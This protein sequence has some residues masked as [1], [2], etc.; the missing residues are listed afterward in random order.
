MDSID[1]KRHFSF[2]F[3]YYW[4][5][6]LGA[7]GYCSDVFAVTPFTNTFSLNARG[8]VAAIGNTNATCFGLNQGE[9]VNCANVQRSDN[10][11]GG[12]LSNNNDW[13]TGANSNRSWV[14]VNIDPVAMQAGYRDSSMAELKLPEGSEVKN[15]QLYW[16]V[17]TPANSSLSSFPANIRHSNDEYYTVVD[18]DF[19]DSYTIDN[20]Q[21]YAAQADVT[22]LIKAGGAGDYYVAGLSDSD[23]GYTGVSS[24]VGGPQAG[25]ALVVTFE[26]D[27]FPLRNMNVFSGFE[28]LASGG[29]PG[30]VP[31]VSTP[32]T[33]LLTPPSGIVNAHI[34][35]VAI[36]GDRNGIDGNLQFAPMPSDGVCLPSMSGWTNVPPNAMNPV[37]NI[38]N[39]TISY[40]GVLGGYD[41]GIINP[42]YNN[43]LVIDIDTFTADD[44]LGVGNTNGI[45]GACARLA[46]AST[47]IVFPQ[48]LFSVIDIFLPEFDVD[49]MKRQVNLTHPELPVGQANAGDVIEYTLSIVNTG[50]DAAVDVVLTDA[51]PFGS[52]YVPG[53]LEIVSGVNAGPKTDAVGDDQAEFVAGKVVFRLGQGANAT[54]GGT[55]GEQGG[56]TAPSATEVRFKVRVNSDAANAVTNFADISYASLTLST[57]YEIQSNTVRM[58]IIS[59]GGPVF[60]TPVPVYSLPVL[61]LLATMLGLIAIRQKSLKKNN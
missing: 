56:L 51:I 28:A 20:E 10:Y 52:S 47:E 45:E 15:A 60:A 55:I 39:S 2:L 54:V 44:F 35:W 18:F 25:W 43:T 33:G 41:G 31:A 22:D 13:Q 42:S 30:V 6:F 12:N 34:G 58:Q 53:S 23:N 57:P 24:L 8:D 32:L 61:V 17:A 7:V 3:K 46:A 9:S 59:N 11:S 48:S 16:N 38:G 26:N 5:F 40:L 4:I 14:Y 50:E 29:Y 49:Q 19:I 1:C 36:D 37:N 21:F 27:S